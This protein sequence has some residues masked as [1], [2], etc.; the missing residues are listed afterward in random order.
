MIFSPSLKPPDTFLNKY[1]DDSMWPSYM[2]VYKKEQD[3]RKHTDFF[4]KNLSID[5]KKK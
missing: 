1:R 3:Q 5:D 4:K 2:C